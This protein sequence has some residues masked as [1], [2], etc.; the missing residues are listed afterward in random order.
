[1]S[2]KI[3]KLSIGLLVVSALSLLISIFVPIWRIELAAPQYPEGLM[4]FIYANRIGGN[5]DIING[6]NH[7]I[8]MKT[9]H[10]NDFVEFTVLPYLISALILLISFSAYRAR[11]SWLYI[12]FAAIAV[13][14]IAAMVDFWFWEYDYGH[15]LNPDAAIIVPGM[16]YQPPLIGYK[17]LLNFGAYSVPDIG[18]WLFVLAGILLLIATLKESG[19]FRRSSKGKLNFWAPLLISTTFLF[20]CGNTGSK[21]IALN[22]DQCQSCR[23]TIVNGKYAAEIATV[24]GRFY[25]FDD[26]YCL[27]Q[28]MSNNED[29][30]I[31]SIYIG[32][33][34]KN[35]ELIDAKKA[36]YV[37]HESIKSPMGGNTAAFSEKSTADEFALKLGSK[38]LVWDDLQ[39][40]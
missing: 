3:S 8:G 1:M 24:K 16:S 38:V 40:K 9:L 4:L 34:Q 21:E 31:R 6:L 30:D 10:S 12:S 39:R 33:F 23:M 36:W 11:K 20:S 2:N 37:N 22:S 18:G 5:V 29:F 26:L 13:F 35:N 28:F 19:L 15:N 27:H 32:D 7:Y 14:G 25:V 17:Q